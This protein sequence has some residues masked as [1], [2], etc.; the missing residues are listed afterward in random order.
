MVRGGSS[1]LKGGAPPPPNF[2]K[3]LAMRVSILNAQNRKLLVKYV[4]N[5]A[6]R[7]VLLNFLFWHHEIYLHMK[8]YQVN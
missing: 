5:I 4:K 1:S 8:G 2:V 3:E 6:T 7:I